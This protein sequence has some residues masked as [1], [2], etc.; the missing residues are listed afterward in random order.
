M[1]N[2]GAITLIGFLLFVFGF[3]AMLLQMVGVNWYFLQFLEWGGR[4]FSFVV[5]VLMTIGGVLLVVV[6][7]TDWER[8]RREIEADIAREKEEPNAK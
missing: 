6:A 8:E 2:K 1:K 5:K 7:N 4:L 3:T